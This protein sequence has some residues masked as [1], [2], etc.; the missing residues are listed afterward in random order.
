MST[1]LAQEKESGGSTTVRMIGLAAA[2]VAAAAYPLF[3]R[4]G[5]VRWGAT[6]DEVRGTLPGDDL[7]KESLCNMTRAITINAPAAEIW[8]WLVQMGSERAGWYSYDRLDNGGKPSADRIIPDFQH[9]KVGDSLVP[10]S[11]TSDVSY[12][13]VE[14][15]DPGRS[16]VLMTRVNGSIS[17]E[18]SWAFVLEPLDNEHTRLIERSRSDF[19]PHLVGKSMMALFEPI[20]FF[21]MRRHLL[22]LKELVERHHEPS[23]FRLEIEQS[24]IASRA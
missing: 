3:I 2:T 20:D 8:P 1:A 17:G 15:I 6:E 7:V 13:V 4:R 10:N 18:S 24:E 19:R 11:N 16:I 22:N 9:L 12:W 14:R 5:Q 21:M 23:A